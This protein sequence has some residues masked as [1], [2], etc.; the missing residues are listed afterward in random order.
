MNQSNGNENYDSPEDDLHNILEALR[1]QALSLERL[2]NKVNRIEKTLSKDF[3]EIRQRLDIME[4]E[5]A[6]R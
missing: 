3:A 1:N 2:A 4:K 5:L 6:N